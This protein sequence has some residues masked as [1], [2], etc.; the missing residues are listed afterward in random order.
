ML[1]K[2]SI[3]TRGGPGRR[4]PVCGAAELRD[5]SVKP[6]N[7]KGEIYLTDI[8]ELCVAEGKRVGLSVCPEQEVQGV[9]TRV[10]LARKHV[11]FEGLPHVH[12]DSR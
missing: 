5:A 11:P 12:E 7:A 3:A 9:N 4:R 6:N 2:A 8:V 1:C 10:Q